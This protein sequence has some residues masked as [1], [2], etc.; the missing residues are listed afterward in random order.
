[1]Q[2]WTKKS[3]VPY[4][5]SC[6]VWWKREHRWVFL[7]P[8]IGQPTPWWDCL[9]R[10]T[11]LDNVWILPFSI[12]QPKR[13]LKI[14]AS[15]CFINT[16]L[17]SSAK[18]IRR[19]VCIAQKL[20]SLITKSE[21]WIIRHLYWALLTSPISTPAY[22]VAYILLSKILWFESTKFYWNISYS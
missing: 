13:L 17:Q 21:N 14:S 2:Y 19:L 4:L 18:W 22:Q 11:F 7:V 15:S 5:Q 9:A 8:R 16:Y 6:A 10:R 3:Q 1:M 20:A 12:Q